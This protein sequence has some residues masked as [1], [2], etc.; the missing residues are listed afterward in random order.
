MVHRSASGRQELGQF[1]LPFDLDALSPGLVVV[2]AGKRIHC[3][4]DAQGGSGIAEFALVLAQ[5]AFQ[6]IQPPGLGQAGDHM[7]VLAEIVP[8][9]AGLFR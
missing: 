8:Q 5:V 1:Q 4:V 3:S 2:V 9:V 7:Q 6:F